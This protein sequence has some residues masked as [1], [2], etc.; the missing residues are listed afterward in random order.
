MPNLG[1]TTLRSPAESWRIAGDFSPPRG[2]AVDARIDPLLVCV[3][4]YILTA[5]GRVH[6]LFPVLE[7][8]RPATLTGLL[9]I[10]FFLVDRSEQR[11]TKYLFVP[12]TKWLLALVLWCLLSVSGALLP[13]RSFELVFDNFIKTF[14]M[15]LII[16]GS[17]RGALDVER[18][19][20]AYF[21]GAA[22]YA[23]VV[24]TR[25]EVG[26]GGAW[27]LGRLYYYDAN[28]FATFAATAIP[29]GIYF[30]HA[31]RTLTT[32][33]FAAGALG[34]LTLAFVRSG[35]RGGFVALMAVAIFV[36]WRFSS[37][38]LR[39]RLAAA[40]L[41]T[42][43]VLAAASDQ[44]WKQMS[45]ILSD[46]DYNRT[47]ESGR[48]Q[49]WRRGI[50]YMFRDPVFGVGPGNFQ[51]AEGLLSPFAERQ[52]F[53]V[54]VRWNAAHNTYIQVGAELGVPGLVIFAG[55]IIAAFRALRHAGRANGEADST[56]FN[57]RPLTQALTASL[58]GFVVGACFLSLAFSEMLYTLAALAV[59]MD[60]AA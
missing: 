4:A 15:Y 43:V 52:Q 36:V 3:S 10:L 9:A 60:K 41:V 18:L 56:G 37:I 49:I 22:V 32:R 1:S 33:V 21:V 25:F 17:V 30:V 51:A 5:V 27:R 44:Y 42:V 38:A 16:A 40:A 54:G 19:T 50:G 55:F 6:Q 45:T 26:S 11:R 12:T 58:L 46:A 20:M 14:V 53:G 13:G 35:S 39:W 47:D 24:V 59:A 34:V 57:G 8:F 29:L 2:V 48:M 28:D 31:A 7:G 23:G